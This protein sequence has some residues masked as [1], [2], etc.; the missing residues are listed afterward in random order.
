MSRIVVFG[1]GFLGKIISDEFQCALTD[2]NPIKLDLLASYLDSEKPDVVI[3]AIG[4]TGRPNIDWCEKHKEETMYSNVVAAANLC[5]ECSKRGIYF[6]HL[7]SGCIYS[8]D[9]DGKGF[10]EEDTPNF[11][12]SF[13]SRTKI[14]CENILKEFPGLILRLRM[15]IDNRLDPRNLIDKLTKYPK[16][17][18][19]QNS[20]TTVPHL[21]EAMRKLIEKKATGIY[22]VVNP[23]TSSA[24]EIM[25]LYREIV[26]PSH[27]F[28]DLSL[29]GLNSITTAVRSN[30]KLNSA[31]L[32]KEGII[33]PEIHE[34]I[35]QCMIKYKK[36]KK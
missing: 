33:M 16:I 1:K 32:E 11:T 3:N 4:K 24:K 10:S 17:I 26:D 21:I 31:K 6:V 23:G 27:T 20:M 35:K 14:I 15:P 25:L 18:D 29:E 34:A 12:G 5:M 28:E 7:G 2:I 22:H 9:N 19:I 30:C 36:N 8:G 13:Y